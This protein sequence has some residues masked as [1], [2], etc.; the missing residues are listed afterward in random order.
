MMLKNRSSIIIKYDI[1]FETSIQP[2]K[3]IPKHTIPNIISTILPKRYYNSHER[4]YGIY[5][6]LNARL[7]WNCPWINYL[8]LNAQ[9]LHEALRLLPLRF[10]HV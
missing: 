6:T 2:L 10:Q 5:L 8:P 3:E 7:N 1:D 4:T 9:F